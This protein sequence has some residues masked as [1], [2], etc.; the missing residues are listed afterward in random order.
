MRC[1]WYSVVINQLSVNIVYLLR[2]F[3]FVRDTDKEINKI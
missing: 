1:I 3:G 2:W